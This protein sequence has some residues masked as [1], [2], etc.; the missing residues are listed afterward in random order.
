[1][2][3]SIHASVLVDTEFA[4]VP[5]RPQSSLGYQTTAAFAEILATTCSDAS[6]NVSFA[7]PPVVKPASYGVT[8]TDKA[9]I[10]AGRKFSGRSLGAIMLLGEADSKKPRYRGQRGFFFNSGCGGRI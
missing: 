8:E 4:K 6:L 7:S 9:L 5:S 1:M 3:G 10:A 2:R